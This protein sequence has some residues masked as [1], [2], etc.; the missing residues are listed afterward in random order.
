MKHSQ[1]FGNKITGVPTNIISLFIVLFMSTN[2]SWATGED[3][4]ETKEPKLGDL[5]PVVIHTT[6]P[7]YVE[8]A[9]PIQKLGEIGDCQ[10]ELKPDLNINFSWVYY[11]GQ[12]YTNWANARI[13]YT[14]KIMHTP[15]SSVSDQGL[16]SISLTLSNNK[17]IG[18]YIDQIKLQRYVEQHTWLASGSVIMYDKKLNKNS[19]FNFVS[20]SA[21]CKVNYLTEGSIHI[22]RIDKYINELSKIP[23]FKD[24][25][26]KKVVPEVP[27]SSVGTHDAIFSYRTDITQLWVH[28]GNF[29][30]LRARNYKCYPI[31]EKGRSS[32]QVKG[33]TLMWGISPTPE[34]N[35]ATIVTYPIG[36]SNP[37]FS[38]LQ[39]GS[40]QLEF[41]YDT[42]L[43]IVSQKY[44]LVQQ[45]FDSPQWSLTIT[46]NNTN[47]NTVSSLVC[48][49]EEIEFVK[50]L[51]V[52]SDFSE[53]HNNT[54]SSVNHS[55]SSIQV[56]N[57]SYR[58]RN[59]LVRPI[60]ERDYQDVY[61]EGEFICQDKLGRDLED[62]WRLPDAR[63]SESDVLSKN[64]RSSELRESATKFLWA[65]R[66]TLQGP[67][68]F[69]NSPI[70]SGPILEAKLDK[71]VR[72]W[73][74]KAIS[75]SYTDPYTTRSP[76]ISLSWAPNIN[77]S[78]SASA[79]KLAG[80]SFIGAQSN[81]IK[82]KLD[83]AYCKKAPYFKS[84]YGNTYKYKIRLN[85]S[86]G[87]DASS[88]EGKQ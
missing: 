19:I 56:N 45:G 77:S 70:V 82:F 6:P 40:K 54:G 20:R 49:E 17:Y 61:E 11:D 52:S 60:D 64:P 1:V 74:V 10:F 18:Q 85:P 31:N 26:S 16:T 58:D 4:L 79:D 33:Y 88:A 41:S 81:T 75:F 29:N 72:R 53:S 36:T 24:S 44:K 37:A 25:N 71:G 9:T 50:K 35:S 78:S 86:A 47:K 22:S 12:F 38:T 66:S 67:V 87:S 27:N 2:I 65:F 13:G 62:Y 83:S 32:N 84:L 15:A 8:Q 23:A 46:D 3:G 76:T 42:L 51:N 7:R 68:I 5:P 43:N 39:G 57:G 48:D 59:S 28:S 34:G 69:S 80:W 30:N 21:N 14:E 55:S 73:Y 63:D